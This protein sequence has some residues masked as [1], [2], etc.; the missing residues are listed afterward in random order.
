L[1]ITTKSYVILLLSVYHDQQLCH[2]ITFCL[3]RPRAMSF[4]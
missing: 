3:S 1:S 2:F 4:Y